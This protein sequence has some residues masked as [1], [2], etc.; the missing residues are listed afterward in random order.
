MNYYLLFWV[1]KDSYWITFDYL[2]LQL[3]NID[4]L[5]ALR[6]TTDYCGFIIITDCYTYF[7]LLCLIMDY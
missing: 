6:I 1:T 7:R 4:Y 2:R 5:L 3:I